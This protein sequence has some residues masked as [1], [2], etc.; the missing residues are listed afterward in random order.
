MGVRTLLLLAKLL[1]VD[2]ASPEDNPTTGQ[3]FLFLGHVDKATVD[4]HLLLDAVAIYTRDLGI[5]LLQAPGKPPA[6]VSPTTIDDVVALLRA[7]GARLGFWCQLAPGG[8]QIELVTVDLRRSVAR[9]SF[10]PDGLSRS[11]LYRSI[12]LRLRAILVGAAPGETSSNAVAAGTSPSP[13]PPPAAPVTPPVP[14][15][16]PAD[17]AVAPRPAQKLEAPSERTPAPR[18]PGRGLPADDWPR[19]FFGAGYAL[20]YPLVTSAGAAARHAL[21]LDVMVA[22]HGHLEWDFGTDLA[23]S[24]ERASTAARISVMDIPLRLGGRWVR[25]VGAVTLAGGPFIGLHWLSANASAGMQT[26]QRT[27]L[28]GAGGIDV[29][30]R[31]PSLAGFAAQLRA[32]VEINVPRTRFTINDAPNYDAGAMRLGLDVEIVA[33]VPQ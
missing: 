16:A 18:Q 21:A 27:A 5:A 9:H 26:D 22:T 6:S 10:D 12:A 13:A 32:R 7:R 17:A 2:L 11:D 28:A 33:P 23:P 31:G 4:E 19:M 14:R 29:V 24:T 15:S 8:R 20:S 1:L 25:Q 3:A 30:A